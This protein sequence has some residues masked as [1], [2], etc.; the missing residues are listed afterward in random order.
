[1]DFL[2]EGFLGAFNVIRSGDPEFLNILLV[3]ARTSGLSILM[4]SLMGFPLG[5]ALGAFRFPFRRSVRLISDSLLS[6]PTVVVG[7]FVYALISNRGPFGR[8]QLLFT[9]EGMAIGQAVLALP[10]VVSLTASAVESVDQRL[11]MTLKTL[12]ARGLRLLGSVMLEMRHHL[13]MTLM[14]AYGRVVAEVGVSMMIGGNIRWHTRTITTAVTF[15]ASRGDFGMAMALGLVLLLISALLNGAI[16]FLKG[17][18][19]P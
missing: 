14:T 3:T 17:R 4:A 6:V 5:V 8:A 18:W 10:I 12:G 19:R 11:V 15:E 7:L 13:L 1:M 2:A 9:V 16:S